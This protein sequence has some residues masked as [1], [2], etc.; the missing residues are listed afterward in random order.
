MN[1]LIEWWPILKSTFSASTSTPHPVVRYQITIR[2]GPSS[3]CPSNQSV[4]HSRSLS[5]G[6]PST[7]VEL[8]IR[9]LD[10]AC[11]LVLKETTIPS[12]YRIQN[13]MER[14]F[15]QAVPTVTQ[16]LLRSQRSSTLLHVNFRHSSG[17]CSFLTTMYEYQSASEPTKD[18]QM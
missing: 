17:G 4:R 18:M 11:L 2:L 14:L 9:Y 13:R 5:I 8:W 6:H 3:D 10:S 7:S 15:C 12:Q 1:E 16:S